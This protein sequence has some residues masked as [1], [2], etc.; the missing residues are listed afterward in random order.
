MNEYNN[1][2]KDSPLPFT[3]TRNKKPRK[4][5]TNQKSFDH[6][7]LVVGSFINEGSKQRTANQQKKVLKKLP[8]ILSR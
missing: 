5:K 2:K 7:Y 8:N 6:L 4:V 1:H 3:T